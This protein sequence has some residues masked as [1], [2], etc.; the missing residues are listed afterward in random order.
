MLAFPIV[1][2]FRSADFPDALLKREA[3]ERFNPEADEDLYAVL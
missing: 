1:G 2:K 3:V